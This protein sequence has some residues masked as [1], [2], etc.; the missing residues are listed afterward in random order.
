MSPHHTPNI[1]QGGAALAW[2]N[3]MSAYARCVVEPPAD[4]QRH[5]AVAFRMDPG[6]PIAMTNTGGSTSPP[7]A[8]WQRVAQKCAQRP[9]TATQIP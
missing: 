8:Q 3:A 4:R 1:D 9:G 6:A 7:P 2:T 5:P